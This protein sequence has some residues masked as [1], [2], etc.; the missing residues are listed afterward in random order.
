MF[1]PYIFVFDQMHVVG[2]LEG[3]L[4]LHVMEVPLWVEVS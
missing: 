1:N 4:I 3:L 2:F